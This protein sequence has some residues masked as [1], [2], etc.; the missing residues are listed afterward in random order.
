MCRYYGKQINKSNKRIDLCDVIV[1]IFLFVV[2]C[3]KAEL[4]G[5]IYELCDGMH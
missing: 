4:T 3:I 1:N 5:V 2:V